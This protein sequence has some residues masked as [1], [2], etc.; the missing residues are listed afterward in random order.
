MPRDSD[1][2]ALT[3][4]GDDEPV[5]TV[6]TK[7]E[8]PKAPP[9]ST[10]PPGWR[11]VGK[12]GTPAPVSNV[13]PREQMGSVALVVHGILGG[14]YLLYV[15]G[16][17]IAAQRDSAAPAD[18]IGSAMYSVG[19]WFAVLAPALWFGTVLWLTKGATSSRTRLIWL[20]VGV[21]VLVPIPFLVGGVA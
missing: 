9:V 10:V 17:L 7:P 11:V 14:I 3:W 1:D 6:S 16:W 21:I 4:A 8:S 12:P 2:D 13:E 18:I 20:G 5:P 19:L 15:I